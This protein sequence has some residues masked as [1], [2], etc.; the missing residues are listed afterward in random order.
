MI[1]L[2]VVVVTVVV[3]I[4]EEVELDCCEGEDSVCC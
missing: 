1:D 2:V 4:L 3:E